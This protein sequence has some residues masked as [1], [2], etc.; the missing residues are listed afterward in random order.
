MKRLLCLS[1]SLL[2][3]VN[4]ALGGN[5]KPV[6]GTFINLAYQDVRNK[7]TNPEGM[8]MTAPELWEAK[9]EEMSQM[10]MEYL[11]FMAVANEGRAY[12]PS[13]LMPHHYPAGRK[14]PVEA[15][16]DAAAEHNMRVFMSTGWAEDQDD[17]L[18]IPRIK[19][20]QMD[21][22]VELARLFGD[23]KAFY[24]W[25]LPVEDCLG[26]VLTDY[27]VEAVNALTDHARGLTPKAKI[28]ISPYGIFNS[29][30]DHPNYAR[31][32]ER[33][34]VD[35]IAYQDEVG[36]VRE[37]FPLP[38][39]RENW[40][41]LAAIHANLPIEIWANCESFTWE[42]GTND[43]TSALIPAAPER[44]VAQLEAAS[45]AGVDRIV[46][47]IMCGIFEAEDSPYPLGQ[48]EL[49]VAAAR[50]YVAW[51]RN[52]TPLR[53]PTDECVTIAR[54][55]EP[56]IVDGTLGDEDT[57]NSA[58]VRLPKGTTEFSLSLDKAC[59]R[60]E[61]RLG[62]L[63]YVPSGVCLPERVALYGSADGEHFD[64]LA[65]HRP[66]PWQNNRHDAWVEEIGLDGE[67]QG[68]Q[69]LRLVLTCPADCYVDE[70]VVR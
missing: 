51:S 26:P 49:S 56:K 10:G 22:M 5:I 40:K 16:L 44:F 58:W 2:A 68:L 28:L 41:R 15:I 53:T 50:E 62:V 31:Q 65:E 21:M 45:S 38:R 42:R 66:Q 36:C 33:L 37:K 34:K 46:S 47:F 63:N 12:Y 69:H 6:T 48:P 29:D 17:N 61:A 11:I 39:L 19:Q 18:R 55:S 32:I 64:L 25:Y 57:A 8:D 23:H 60:V 9:I 52:C 24:G 67:M 54:C 43:R 1:L 14:S 35:I 70:V 30:F 13:E 7:Y 59:D 3:I 20:R 27:A 4:M